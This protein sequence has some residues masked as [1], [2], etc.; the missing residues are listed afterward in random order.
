MGEK[1]NAYRILVERQR[2]RD[3]SED[4]DMDVRKILKW[5]LQRQDDVECAGFVSG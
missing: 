5:I 3:H 2:E 1:R 4:Q